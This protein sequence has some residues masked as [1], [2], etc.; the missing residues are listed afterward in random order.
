MASDTRIAPST[1]GPPVSSGALKRWRLLRHHRQAFITMLLIALLLAGAL[2]VP[3]LPLADPLKP[4]YDRILQPPSRSSLLGTD[5]HGRDQLSRLLWA[6]RPSLA[7]GLSAT[8]MALAAGALIGGLAGWRGRFADSLLMRLADV[9]LAFPI[10]LG[11]IAI[12]AIMGPGRWNVILAIS[13]FGWP[14]FARVF[15]SAVLSTKEDGFVQ[16][17][18]GLGASELRVF[19]VHVLPHAAVPLLTYGAMA[20]AGAMLM[21]AGLS[22]IGLGIQRPYPSWG[23]MLS[24]SMG[25]FTSAPWLVAA[26]GLAVTLAALSFILLGTALNEVIGKRSRFAGGV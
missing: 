3:L 9:F 19:R 22:F 2:L 26:P 4:D 24:E 1:S 25:M 16:A 14:V 18:R 5:T 11:A 6:S 15:R 23:L 21:E 8:A 7:I 12:V 13:L 20:V 17:A 10:I